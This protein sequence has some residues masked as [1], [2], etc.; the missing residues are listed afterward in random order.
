MEMNL[1]NTSESYDPSEKEIS[2]KKSHSTSEDSS[3]ETDS[4]CGSRRAEKGEIRG[5][6]SKRKKMCGHKNQQIQQTDDSFPNQNCD[7]DLHHS[8]ESANNKTTEPRLSD[9]NVSS[10][11]NQENDTDHKNKNTVI[12]SDRN[13]SEKSSETAPVEN[14]EHSNIVDSRRTRRNSKRKRESEDFCPVCGI[15]LRC[16]ELASHYAKEVE[17]LSK[18][19]KSVKKTRCEENHGVNTTFVQVKSNRENRHAA[20]VA[21]FSSRPRNEVY[22][23]VCNVKLSGSDDEI[24]SHVHN[25]ISEEEDFDSIIIIDDETENRFE[26]YVFA[27]QRRVRAISMVPGGYKCLQAVSSK[28]RCDDDDDDDEDLNVDVDDTLTYGSPQYTELDVIHNPTD[29]TDQEGLE[30]LRKAVLLDPNVER[31]VIESRKWK[32]PDS[33]EPVN[34][35]DSSSSLDN[36][37]VEANTSQEASEGEKYQESSGDEAD[38]HIVSSLKEKIRDLEEQNKSV[39]CLICLE[40]YTKPVVSTTCWHVHC[41]EC[42]L[43]T[44]G[45]KKLC[46]QCNIIVFPSDLRR[47]YL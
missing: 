35:E 47:I 8:E 13:P 22:C 20:K 30:Q 43:M 4:V 24:N 34:S 29:D 10:L 26:E 1:N 21:K 2:V 42:W 37:R 32:S 31:H 9:E 40:P 36:N 5:T 38:D 11:R 23:P 25:C 44:M 28:P 16:S 46:P 12:P 14:C 6:H 17:N 3:C 18:I 15:T 27:D 33:D 45:V 7:T 39:K 41:E 19:S